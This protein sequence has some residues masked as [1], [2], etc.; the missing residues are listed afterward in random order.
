MK[1][2]F[3]QFS[4][5]GISLF[6]L[7][8][9]DYKPA[10][11][12]SFQKI[13]VFADSTIYKSIQPE[14]EQTFD[15]FVYTPHSERSFFLDFHPVS[16][17]D[18]Y[19]S[20]RNILFIGVIGA[21]DAVS[22]FVT[23]SLSEQTRQAV[24]ENKVF[25]IFRDNI[26]ASE[27]TVMFF[28]GKDAEQIAKNLRDRGQLIFEKLHA[29][30]LTKMES[31]MFFE[32]EQTT[33]EE[34]LA[35][36]Y[37]WKVR[38]QHDYRLVKEEPGGKV[39]WFR[40]LNPD[41]NLFIYRFPGE[42]NLD[43]VDWTFDLRDSLTTIYY[44][45]DSIDRTDSYAQIIDFRGEKAIKLT[46]IWQNHKLLIGGPFRTIIFYDPAT[47]YTYLLDMCVTA[48]GEMKK[49]YLDQLEIMARSFS[50]VGKM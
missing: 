35:K 18:T 27:Q 9:C 38:V 41:R 2:S 3:N 20:R 45:A 43:K 10:S 50:S 28:P 44:E 19:K 22:E 29:L 37:D 48:P 39:V 26:F 33:L 6:L 34:Y 25:E 16:A 4:V 32:G 31:A 24:N 46:G 13:I 23:G 42:K 1:K 7:F 47:G 11:F 5:I 30:Y 36:S 8:A 15:Q 17:L 40:R 12:G 14:L 21:S 49:N